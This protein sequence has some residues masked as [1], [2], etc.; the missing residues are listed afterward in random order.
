MAS[1]SFAN[2][3]ATYEVPEIETRLFINNEFVPSKSG[4]KFDVINPATEQVTTSVYE[5]LAE[6]TNLA[7]KA[8]KTAFPAWAALSGFQRAAYFYKLADLLEQS[9]SELAKL[10]AVSMG[11]PVGVYS[12]Y[13]PNTFNNKQMN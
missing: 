3:K 10:E 8:A 7:V 2:D 11:K 4:T 5:A 12:L 13:N 9:N 6:D 1:S